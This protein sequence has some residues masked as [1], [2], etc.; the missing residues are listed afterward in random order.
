M[1]FENLKLPAA[2]QRGIDDAGFVEC[3]SI[4]EQVLPW[5][6][7][8]YDVAGQAQ[9]GTGKTA[10]FL[11]TVF[12]RLL[13]N[14][15][16]L[17]DHR[18]RGLVI[19]PTRELAEQ[20]ADDANMLGKHTDLS[21]QTIYGGVG[22]NAQRRALEQGVDL[23]IGTPGRLIDYIK[24][25]EIKLSECQAVVIDEADRMFDMGFIHD[26]RY[27]LRRLSREPVPQMMLFS[28][29]LSF[30]VMDLAYEFMHEPREFQVEPE[31]VV[32]AQIEETVYH[33]GAHEKLELL[34]GLLR[35]EN[36]SRCMVFC[37]TKAGVN[38][39]CDV[40]VGNEHKAAMISGDLPQVKRQKTVDRYKAGE[41]SVLVATD[42]AS[43]GLHVDDVTHVVNYDV[44]QDPEDYVH[45][46]GRTARMGAKGVA[47][48][49]ACERFVMQLPA[50]ER[51]IK[52]KIPVGRLADDM[53]AKNKAP[54]RSSNRQNRRRSESR[55][56]PGGQSNDA[57]RRGRRGGRKPRR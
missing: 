55:G 46:I 47:I 8:G 22:Y 9:T 32:V 45:R 19:A 1:L 17:R 23:V 43:R 44:P 13:N 29:T 49:L 53:F 15:R 27:I 42:V 16:K 51:Y 41:I 31:Q 11:L 36:P 56:K 4:Q 2:V 48:T 25:G 18:P 40:L 28:A 14:P 30:T 20:I 57:G 10:T 5:S 6:L 12:A 34:L 3:T 39:V 24:R 50:V 37:N 35:D 7:D 54:S 38:R 26:L 21:I 52:H 33:V